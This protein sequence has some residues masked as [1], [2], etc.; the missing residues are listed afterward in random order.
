MSRPVMVQTVTGPVPVSELG[1]TVTHEHVFLDSRDGFSA[2]PDAIDPDMP[3]TPQTRADVDRYPL[4]VRDNLLLDDLDMAVQELRT[5][6]DAGLCTLVEATS[7]YT[8]RQ[9]ARLFA[10]ARASEMQ[11]VMGSGLYMERAIPPKMRDWSEAALM[12]LIEDDLLQGEDTVHGRIRPGVIGEVGVSAR[13]TALERRS[14]RASARV[15]HAHGVPLSVHLPAWDQVGHEVLDEVLAATGDIRGVLLGHLNPMAHDL[16]YMLSLAGR[17]AWLGLDMMG[18]ALDYG[19]GRR[20][21]DDAT[22]IANLS[23]LLSAG[24]GP[25]LLLS[26]DVGQKNML[27]SNGGQGYGHVLDRILPALARTGLPAQTGSDLVTLNPCNWFLDA[28]GARG[29]G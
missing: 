11:I 5:A 15:A 28:A 10:A 27:R 14:L 16:D 4:S 23:T 2:R 20:S 17:G 12:Q 3:V 25:H 8:G 7:L 21:P 6:R 18:N 13:P 1:P 26:S 22:N 24:L 9:P 19:Q 29:L